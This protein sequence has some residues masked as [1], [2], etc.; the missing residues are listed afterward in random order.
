ML[1][2]KIKA[3]LKQ[4]MID[5]DDFKKSTLRI[6]LGEIPRLNLKAGEVPTDEQIHDIIR[7]C[8]K[9]ANTIIKVCEHHPTESKYIKILESYLPKMMDKNEICQWLVS[10]RDII[11]LDS[12]KPQIKAMGPIMKHLKGKADGNVVREILEWND[13]HKKSCHIV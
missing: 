13:N 12:F 1:I 10:N 5:R 6:L 9:A 8:I 4:A 3:E 7:K 11:D 2:D